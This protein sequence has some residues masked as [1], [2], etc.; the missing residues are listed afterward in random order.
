MMLE[1]CSIFLPCWEA[2]KHQV[3]RQETL[4]TIAA[5]Q[6]KQGNLDQSTVVGSATPTQKSWLKW[7]IAEKTPASSTKGSVSTNLS[8]E[9]LHSMGALERTLASDPEPLRKFSALNDFSGENVAFLTSVAEWKKTFS[10]GLHEENRR[11]AYIRALVVYHEFVSPSGAEFPV[12]LS[13]QE[14][15]E[16]DTTFKKAA[17][18]VYGDKGPMSPIHPFV[19]IELPRYE[20]TRARLTSESEGRIIPSRP[21]SD[22]ASY[23]GNIPTDFSIN[24]FDHSE[25]S[26]KYLVLTNTW[27]KFIQRR[28]SSETSQTSSKRDTVAWIE[29]I[30]SLF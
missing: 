8:N 11:D 23:W 3:L 4:D 30:T 17:E 28:R 26:I 5:W 10:A 20:S 14:L 1:I 27:P 19:A 21:S 6:A 9:S 2:Y 29:R 25:H 16:L 22:H 24:V 13:Y 15:A 7:S 12:N 18:A